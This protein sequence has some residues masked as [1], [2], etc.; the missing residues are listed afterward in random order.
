MQRGL[1]EILAAVVLQLAD[2]ANGGI[3]QNPN[4]VL[5]VRNIQTVEQI[6]NLVGGDCGSGGSSYTNLCTTIISEDTE[7]LTDTIAVEE[8]FFLFVADT[9]GKLRSE[10]FLQLEGTVAEQFL[11]H[12][13]DCADLVSTDLL[14]AESVIAIGNT[15]FFVDPRS[16]ALGSHNRDFVSAGGSRKH[17]G[18]RTDDVLMSQC[19]YEGFLKFIGNEEASFGV[20]TF[21]QC[22]AHF[23]SHASSGTSLIPERFL[24]CIAGA[25]SLGVGLGSS[26]LGGDRGAGRSTHLTINGFLPLHAVDLCAVVLDLLLHLGISDSILCSKQSVLV[27][28]GFYK[29]L[30]SFPSLIA[31]HT[32]F[33][34]SHNKLPPVFDQIEPL[35]KVIGSVG[36]FGCFGF[37]AAL[38]CQL[39][40]EGVD[41]ACFGIHHGYSGDLHVFGIAAALEDAVSKA[42]LHGFVC[43]HPC[44]RIHEVTE[45]GAGHVGLDLIGVDDGILH[46]GQHF[47]CFLHFCRIT[48]SAGHGVM[49]HHHRHRGH[50]NRR[51]CHGDHR[52]CG[53]CD[54]VNFYGYIAG[55]VHQHVVNLGCCNTV[56]T[57]AVDPDGDIAA[58]GHQFL[59][60][61]LGCYIIVK[62]TFLCDGAAQMQCPFRWHR[63]RRRLVL[64]LPELLHRL[65]SPF[66]LMWGLYLQKRPRC[67]AEACCR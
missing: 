8:G 14:L 29:S 2:S 41:H 66:R 48:E 19:C 51:T 46:A 12:L 31:L 59:P 40:H 34:D 43:V 10:V 61:Q 54:A 28:L 38:G 1:P 3:V 21:L 58:A 42:K 17:M 63:L 50:E 53:G 32:Q 64:P 20:N 15:A 11:R 13:D 45:L 67:I 62:P 55:V 35:H 65:L 18:V 52:G 22:I 30:C 36:G 33:V 47:N 5:P 9:T 25:A 37:D 27:T 39:F 56:A 6:D 23:G 44:F 26:R 24:V 60:E 4:G 49:D 57:G 7:G 16:S